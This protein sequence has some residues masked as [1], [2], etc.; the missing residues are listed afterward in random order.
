[1]KR[2]EREN[3]SIVSYSD[4]LIN[5]FHRKKYPLSILENGVS[6]STFFD[7]H[8]ADKT[9]TYQTFKY[10]NKVTQI[11]RP[12]GLEETNECTSIRKSL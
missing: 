10:N 11:S 7:R 9:E 8:L 12:L 2:K 4:R 6:V 3:T 1:M 5:G